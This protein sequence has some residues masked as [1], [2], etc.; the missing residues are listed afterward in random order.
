MTLTVRREQ[1]NDHATVRQLHDEAFGQPLEGGIVECLRQE[2]P[3]VLSLVAERD[4]IIVG[5]VMFSAVRVTGGG[6]AVS[7]MGLAPM[8][9][10]PDHQRRGVGA[11]LVRDGLERLRSADCPFVIVLGHEDYYPRFGFE[12]ASG[13][14]FGC[15]WEGVPDLAFMVAVLDEGAVGSVTGV[16]RYHAAFDAAV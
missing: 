5:H 10:L 16:V 13:R 11:A 7:G 8:A 1:E 9:V 14:G 6:Q 12:P 4:G 2:C 15:P 3:D